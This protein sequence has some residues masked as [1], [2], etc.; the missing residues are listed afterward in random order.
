ME[1]RQLNTFQTVAT[2]LNFSRAAEALNYVPSNVTM[3]I[4]AL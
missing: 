1:L 3:Q 2:T 4:K